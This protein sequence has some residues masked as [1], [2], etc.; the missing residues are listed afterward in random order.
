MSG[1]TA[2]CSYKGSGR[3]VLLDRF[4]EFQFIVLRTGA[5]APCLPQLR[6][7]SRLRRLRSAQAC[8]PSDEGGG[9]KGRRERNMLHL[10]AFSLPQS[11]SLT[12]PSTEGAFGAL[13]TCKINS[14]L[15]PVPSYRAER[16]DIVRAEGTR[17][18]PGHPG[19]YQF[20]KTKSTARENPGG[21]VFVIVPRRHRRRN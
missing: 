18:Q 10:L 15:S 2:H 17:S 11:A 12:A 4:V 8:G 20:G 16:R 7:K 5:G 3:I 6:A 19:K 21:C 1:Y 9:P 13:L 14:N